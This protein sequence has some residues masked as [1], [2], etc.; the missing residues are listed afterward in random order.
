MVGP[1]SGWTWGVV[2]E[3]CFASQQEKPDGFSF[4]HYVTLCQARS[5]FHRFRDGDSG[6]PVFII[7]DME[8]SIVSLVGLATASTS[9]G[10]HMSF[11]NWGEISWEVDGYTDPRATD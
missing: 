5:T 6:S 9:Y 1:T 11:S 3:D 8:A 4:T 2:E 10:R 7:D